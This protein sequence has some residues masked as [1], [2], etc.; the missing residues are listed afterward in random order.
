MYKQGNAAFSMSENRIN[1]HLKEYCQAAGVTYYSSHKF[2]FYVAMQLYK[3]GVPLDTICYYL[4]HST[5]KMTE[6]YLR[7]TP[8]DADTEII[9][10]VF[11]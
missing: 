10:R 3:A 5:L 6:H 9:E 4:G 11:G 1:T 7:L 8:E 2:R